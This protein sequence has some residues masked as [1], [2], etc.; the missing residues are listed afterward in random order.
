M[1]AAKYD[2]GF[3][4]GLMRKDFRHSLCKKRKSKTAVTL[5]LTAFSRTSFMLMYKSEEQSLGTSSST[6][7]DCI[8]IIAKVEQMGLNQWLILPL[9]AL[10]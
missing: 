7:S 2:F 6:S 5:P 9:M 3:A 10:K 8:K 4:R 1:S